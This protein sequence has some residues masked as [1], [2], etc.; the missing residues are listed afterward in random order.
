MNKKNEKTINLENIAEVKELASINDVN[1]HIRLGWKLLEMYK[2][3]GENQSQSISYC[4][5]WPKSL[6]KSVAP[7]SQSKPEE[8]KSSKKYI[9]S[10]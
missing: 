2:V 5:G 6:A 4:M 9:Y 10:F 8:P 7:V 1:A 3:S